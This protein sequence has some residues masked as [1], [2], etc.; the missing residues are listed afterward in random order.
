MN[1][2]KFRMQVLT[3]LP[4]AVVPMLIFL[5]KALQCLSRP[6]TMCT[7]GGWLGGGPHC[8]SILKSFALWHWVS[9]IHSQPRDNLKALH[10]DLKDPTL[11]FPPLCNCPQERAL[12]PS[13][14]ARETGIQLSHTYPD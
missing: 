11:K 9:F 10:A 8:S 4:G 12:S 7:T 14:L 2:V 1:L 13:T 3:C 5:S 6:P